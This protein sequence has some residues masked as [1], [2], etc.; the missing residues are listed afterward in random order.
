MAYVP[1]I[2]LSNYSFLEGASFPEELV[3][4]AAVYDLPAMAITDR[5]GMYGLVRAHVTAKEAGVRLIAGSSLRRSDGPPLVLLAMNI[6]GYA[7]LCHLITL[8]RGQAEK[9]QSF[10][11]TQQILERSGNDVLLIHP[12]LHREESL[13]ALVSHFKG[14]MYGAL[15]RYLTL[16]DEYRLQAVQAAAHQ[17]RIPLVV[18]PTFYFHAP[19]R[20]ALCDVLTS[21]RLL[22]P[23]EELGQDLLPNSLF[24]LQPPSTMASLYHDFPR[25][26]ARTVDVASRCSF[27]VQE[28]SYHYPREVVPEGSTSM[29]HL[30][31]LVREGACRRYPDGVPGDVSA[32]L[33]KELELIAE[34]NYPNYFL[35]MHDI[36][37]FAR[38][39]GILCQGRG[40]AANSA[41]CFVLGITSVDPVRS[42]LLFERFLSRERNEPPDIDV[43]FEHERR[44]EVIQYIYNRYGRDRAAMVA[45]FIRYR[46]RSA[47]RD[48]GKAL[49]FPL[50]QLDR[51]S[52]LAHSFRRDG[53]EWWQDAT[54][55]AG[56]DPAHPRVR[57]FE[58]LLREIRGF[59]RHLSIHVGGFILSDI[60]IHELV[61]V[62]PARMEGRT[63]I[64]WDKE[65]VEDAG[66]LKI[67][68]LAL[69]MLS[70]IRRC[71][72]L[73][74]DHKDLNYELATIPAEDP[75]TYKMIQAADTV[76]VFQIESR[77]QMSMLP[78]L[79][80][81]TFYDLVVEV[82]LVRPGPIQGKMVHPYLMRRQG[83]QPVT[84]PIPELTEVLGRTYG[85]PLFQE[86]VMKLAMV[87]AGFTAGEADSLRRAMGAWRTSGRLQ[88]ILEMFLQRMAQRGIEPQYAQQIADQIKGFAE[89][90]FPESHAASFALLA[91]AS[92]W[93]KCHHPDVYLAAILNSQPMGFYAPA[94]LIEDG[95][96]HGVAV[97]GI[98]VNQSGW[99][100]TL[101]ENGPVWEEGV[102]ARP[103]ARASSLDPRLLP[104]RLGF[105]LLRGFPRE[106]ADKLVAEREARGP[107][108]SVADLARRTG[109]PVH[110]QLKLAL[111][112]GFEE[113]GIERRQS[114]WD[115]LNVSRR[116]GPLLDWLEPGPLP[117]CDPMTPREVLVAE[118]HATQQYGPFH[119]MEWVIPAMRQVRGYVTSE[120][121]ASVESGRYVTVAGLVLVR[122]RP[123]TAAGMAFLTLEDCWGFLNLVIVPQVFRTFRRLLAEEF[124]ISAYGR[125]ERVDG[126]INIRVQRMQAIHLEPEVR[127]I[128]SRDYV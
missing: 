57:A 67:D 97:R 115:V 120:E 127:K 79:K 94:T 40:S 11:T 128:S 86:Q 104:V 59:P 31:V 68:V 28:L 103:L 107:Y 116:M 47:I 52:T 7:A 66:L 118:L 41:V 101:E 20:K 114:L 2:T 34:L 126:V 24:A 73:L 43:D 1:L 110:V 113:M 121:L 38:S 124:L 100:S 45:E 83:L 77:A 82:A 25:E 23:V 112:G 5:D 93:L 122:Q 123:P 70:C 12:A 64:Q 75:A 102:S 8:G 60:P 55:S 27:S 105:S 99:E 33:R 91:Y 125:V 108:R 30:E 84:Y 26:L 96:R 9:G 13:P 65:D 54:R 90:G 56:M 4:Q 62:E 87:A 10:L 22:K 76:G 49:G 19:R 111:A 53:E 106:A 48:V 35:T 61:P 69:G 21:I 51:L 80:P 95:R 88:G 32:Q 39:Q 37:S 50:P 78:R 17:H 74:S 119:P 16:E 58:S 98:C 6:K 81:Q 42:N 36:V 3:T 18:A 14:R 89:Y 72:H 46:T 29:G 71:F 15:A 63:V 44:E 85:V 117:V 92:S 109:L